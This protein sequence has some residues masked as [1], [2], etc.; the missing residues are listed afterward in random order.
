MAST[1][2]YPEL[3][4]DCTVTL[5][6]TPHYASSVPV[7]FTTVRAVGSGS[8]G[9]VFIAKTTDGQSVAVKKVFQDRKYRNRELSI[10]VEL[11][12]HP[13]LVRLQNFYYSV[14][15]NQTNGNYLNIVMDYYPE[16]GYQVY[17]SFFRSGNPMPLSHIKLYS[18]QM[19]RGLAYMHTM[20]IANRDLKPQNTLINRE[21]GRAVLCDL[22]SAKKL[23]PSEANIAYICSRYYRAPELIFGA[24]YYGCEIDVWSFGCVVAE[25]MIGRPI[26]AGSSPL[27]QIIEIIKVLGPPTLRELKDMNPTLKEYTFPSIRTTPLGDVLQTRDSVVLDF[28]AQCFKYSPR[29]R[30]TAYQALAHPFYDDLRK[31]GAVSDNLKEAIF[32]F[33]D[34]EKKH[35][36]ADIWEK[37][38]PF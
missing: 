25:M 24:R 17:K 12:N 15:A 33:G 36:S 30:I 13:C 8:F 6:A 3:F 37:L 22:G 38:K 19:L 35:I 2:L 29:E 4:Q 21:T 5:P 32:G 11:G 16:N 28:L 20:K 23:D 7:T 9:V 14:A 1:Q 31:P 34:W 27:D 10:M 26:F 18:Y